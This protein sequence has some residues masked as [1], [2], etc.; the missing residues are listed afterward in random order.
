MRSWVPGRRPQWTKRMWSCSLGAALSLSDDN[1][2][3][4]RVACS[5]RHLCF[6]RRKLA[7]FRLPQRSMVTGI[8]KGRRR[9]EPATG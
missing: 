3:F 5:W 6:L 9:E 4:H 1:P 8:V 7:K 2:G